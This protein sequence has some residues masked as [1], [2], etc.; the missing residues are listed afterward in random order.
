MKLYWFE[1]TNPQKIRFALEEAGFEYELERV[2]LY[3]RANL[4]P[5]FEAVS[6]R[7]K[8][9]VFVDE[10]TAI[11]ESGAILTYLGVRYGR[12][13]PEDP[14][15]LAQALSLLYTEAAAFQEPAGAFFWARVI[16]PRVGKT[17]DPERLEK[18]RKK[19][20]PLLT[21]LERQLEGKEYLLGD[22]SLVDCAYAPWLP[23]LELDGNPAV[24]AW[25]DRV[26]ERPAWLRCKE[27]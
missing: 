19:I 16:L 8:L 25:R 23:H 21:L 20:A 3:K 7:R 12:L 11:Y 9:P 26:V 10:G 17:A 24:A 13:W 22:F 15:T 14:A 2:N 6:P 27:G 5:G 18:A 4:E 1:S